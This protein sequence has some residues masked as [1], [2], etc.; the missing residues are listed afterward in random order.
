MRLQQMP[1]TASR[2]EWPGAVGCR[3]AAANGGQSQRTRELSRSV[4]ALMTRTRGHPDSRVVRL[5]AAGFLAAF[6]IG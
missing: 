3:R 6:S 1:G 2:C 5:T 4:D